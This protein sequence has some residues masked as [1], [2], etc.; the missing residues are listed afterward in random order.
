MMKPVD[1]KQTDPRW[2]GKDYS[3]PGEKTTIGK[4]GCGPSCMAMVIATLADPKIT[5]ADTAAWALK[6]GYKAPNQGTY[7]SYFVPQGKAYGIEVEQVNKSDLRKAGTAARQYHDKAL[8]AIKDGHMVIC[9]M[10]PG[11]WTKAGHYIL[12]HEM[13]GS[14]ALSNDPGSSR[15][16]RAKAPLPTLQSQ[17]KFYWIIKVP[18]TEQEAPDTSVSVGA[19]AVTAKGFMRSGSSY[20]PVRAV[21][22]ALG[23]KV[24]WDAKT[25][26]V[27]VNG[28]QLQVINAGGIAYA[29][30]RDL[31]AILGVKV[32]W[33]ETTKTVVFAKGE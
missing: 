13:E 23:G 27:T 31:A 21:A 9:C 17:V 14:Q 3:A 20:V 5:P 24:G 12:W 6:K 19:G 8:Q 7:Y 2:A 1:Y 15:A 32:D 4:A 29:K 18:N 16:D 11:L 28:K 30:A 25:Q 26:T 33:I 22:E 10:G